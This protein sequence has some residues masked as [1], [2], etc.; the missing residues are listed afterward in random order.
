M[1]AEHLPAWP[2]AADSSTG[3][4]H[5]APGQGARPGR[6]SWLASAAVMAEALAVA[7][8]AQ[9]RRHTR[10]ALLHRSTGS[11]QLGVDVQ[12]LHRLAAAHI[13]RI[14]AQEAVER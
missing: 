9:V 3:P 12:H 5:G 7:A 2:R 13:P 4:R 6:M 11:G 10:I 1:A 8:C 14:G